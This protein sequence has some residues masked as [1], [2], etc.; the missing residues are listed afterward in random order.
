MKKLLN[1]AI[2]LCITFCLGACG[3]QNN[4][5]DMEGL[6]EETQIEETVTQQ[7]NKTLSR[8]FEE[9]TLVDETINDVQFKLPKS[10]MEDIKINQNWHYYYF[11]ELMVGINSREEYQLTNENVIE[12]TDKIVQGMLGENGE[13]ISKR[14]I[15]VSGVKAILFPLNTCENRCFLL[16]AIYKR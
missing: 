12:N 10:W 9:D 5:L 15:E 3:N 7:S 6:G 1:A 11:N 2:I 8:F 14:V 16:P 4:S 13:L